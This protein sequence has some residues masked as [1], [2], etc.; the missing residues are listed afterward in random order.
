MAHLHQGVARV[1]RF[2]TEACKHLRKPPSAWRGG[3]RSHAEE[4][5]GTSTTNGAVHIYIYIDR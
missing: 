1:L 4:W 5:C 3:T 2:S